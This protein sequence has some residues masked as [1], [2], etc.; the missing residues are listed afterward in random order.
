MKAFLQEWKKKKKK[1]VD[2][3]II[4]FSPQVDASE[5]TQEITKPQRVV[6]F[7]L[8]KAWKRPGAQ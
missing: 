2:L 4:I 5:S 8:F 3:P 7:F 1:S 6:L